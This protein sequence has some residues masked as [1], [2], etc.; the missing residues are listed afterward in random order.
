LNKPESLITSVTCWINHVTVLPSNFL[1]W[2]K[3][4]IICFTKYTVACSRKHLAILS[5]GNFFKQEWYDQVYIFKKFILFFK[6]GSCNP[7]WP[8][9]HYVTQYGF[10]LTILLPQPPES[11]DY[12]CETSYLA[13]N[14]L[15]VESQFC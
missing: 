15:W 9:T 6:M 14:S 1:S 11:W 13:T 3:Q 2:H 12:R 10:K 4:T 7:N 8:R 5:K